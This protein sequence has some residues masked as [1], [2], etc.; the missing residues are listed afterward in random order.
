MDR[1]RSRVGGICPAEGRTRRANRRGSA[2]GR[3][4][5][6]SEKTLR[7]PRLIASRAN[8]VRPRA[9]GLN[10]SAVRRC[11]RASLSVRLRLA[12]LM[13]PAALQE[14]ADRLKL[15]ALEVPVRLV[16][17]VLHGRALAAMVAAVARADVRHHVL[18]ILA[19]RLSRQT[20][21]VRVCVLHRGRVEDGFLLVPKANQ[22]AIVSSLRGLR[23]PWDLPHRD[24]APAQQNHIQ[25][26]AAAPEGRPRVV[27]RMGDRRQL[28]DQLR[29]DRL[30]TEQSPAKALGT[31][32]PA[33]SQAVR[34]TSP[35]G[36]TPVLNH[37]REEDS[38]P[39]P[40]PAEGDP[41]RELAALNPGSDQS[42]AAVRQRS[43]RSVLNERNTTHHHRHRRTGRRG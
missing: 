21:A 15:A 29:A 37:L 6:Q 36:R 23:D 28:V 1:Q 18:S 2:H 3:R 31:S 33:R 11:G 10:L 22:Q 5:A 12:V 19:D 39:A 38:P 4:K 13:G 14:R 25:R 35:E 8:F 7:G 32:L 42:P 20:I 34:A 27:P 17:A 43:L 40:D 26:A 24:R 41:G 9:P 30:L 16:L